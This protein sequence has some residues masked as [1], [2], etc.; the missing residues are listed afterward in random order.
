MN[1]TRRQRDRR[2]SA[3]SGSGHIDRKRSQTAT[4]VARLASVVILTLAFGAQGCN[5]EHRG[6]ICAGVGLNGPAAQ[7]P[8]TALVRFIGQVG[9]DRLGKLSDW[10]QIATQPASVEFGARS[11]GLQFSRIMISQSSDGQWSATGACA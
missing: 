3:R 4:P 5:G 10:E 6:A 7:N 8:R 11:A 2:R 1:S 9:R